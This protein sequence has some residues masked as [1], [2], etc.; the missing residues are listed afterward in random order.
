LPRPRD[1]S[2]IAFPMNLGAHMSIAGGLDCALRRGVEE[3]CS[4][5]Q[6]FVK[7]QVR[8]RAADL[9]T[10]HVEAFRAA[11]AETGIRQVIAHGGYL[12]NL[13]A[14]ED[15]LWRK[16]IDAFLVE[17]RRCAA[18]SIP[19][20]VTHP[21]SHRGLGEADGLRRVARAINVLLRMTPSCPVR[22]LLETTAGQGS[23]LGHRF[24][25]LH[26]ILDQVIDPGRIGVCVDT[27]HLFAAGYD[28]RTEAA[29]ERTMAE[30]DRVIGIPRVL[31]FHINDSLRECGSRVDRHAHIGQGHIGL[32]GFAALVRDARF[33]PL[34]MVIET[35]KE[36]KMDRT[37]LQILRD[38]RQGM[39]PTRR[40]AARRNRSR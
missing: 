21:G 40:P 5:V 16:S 29:Y 24:E 22:I 30:L 34:P 23:S 33:R 6:I 8:W 38:L 4:V 28:L 35:P 14:P 15:T 37:N 36:G 27:C 11:W 2:T 7:N 31:A 10:S 12:V 3:T 25:H 20:L 32:A 17:M 9:D 18:L 26:F 39:V 1:S 13:A 19:A